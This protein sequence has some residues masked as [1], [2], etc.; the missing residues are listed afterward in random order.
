[1]FLIVKKKRWEKLEQTVKELCATVE[2][3]TQARESERESRASLAKT[4]SEWVYG[5]EG[6]EDDVE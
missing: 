2:S 1:M 6:G 3:L 4:M 5:K